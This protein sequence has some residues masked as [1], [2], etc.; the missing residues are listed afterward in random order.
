MSIKNVFSF[1][2][3]TV[4]IVDGRIYNYACH[5]LTQHGALEAASAV[6]VAAHGS[7]ASGLANGHSPPAKPSTLRR[8]YPRL[9]DS[10]TRANRDLSLPRGSPHAG[11]PASKAIQQSTLTAVCAGL[12]P[13]RS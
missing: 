10:A 8:R 3:Y 1:S 2:R 7:L 6:H 4:D 13:D 5:A 12:L 11:I 9:R